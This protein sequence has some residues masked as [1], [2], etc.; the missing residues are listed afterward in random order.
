[1]SERHLLVRHAQ[2]IREIFPETN[3]RDQYTA[4]LEILSEL[5][6]TDFI[7]LPLE[8]P[9]DDAGLVVQYSIP[10]DP[11]NTTNHVTLLETIYRMNN[12]RYVADR[13]EMVLTGVDDYTIRIVND[14]RRTLDLAIVENG[15]ATYRYEGKP[16]TLSGLFVF[17]GVD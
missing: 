10:Y 2:A 15:R 17:G 7:D 6:P 16:L 14:V 3:V 1:M 9:T 12:V 4:G 5:L 8:H 11:D 13:I